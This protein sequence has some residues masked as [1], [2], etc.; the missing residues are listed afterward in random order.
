[1]STKKSYFAYSSEFS[2]MFPFGWENR[3]LGNPSYNLPNQNAF[4]SYVLLYPKGP[5]TK[6]L[7]DT[8][9]LAIQ[10]LESQK[11]QAR[12]ASWLQTSFSS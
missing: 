1:M 5:V 7:N 4:P 8:P 2:N 3:L 10:G 6:Q 12:V 11:R 9:N